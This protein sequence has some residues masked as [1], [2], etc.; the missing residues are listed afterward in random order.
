MLTLILHGPSTRASR[1]MLNLLIARGK[2]T[3]HDSAAAVSNSVLDLLFMH[4]FVNEITHLHD[5][6]ILTLALVFMP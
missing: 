3:Q 4:Y 1:A 5:L 6:E 2:N